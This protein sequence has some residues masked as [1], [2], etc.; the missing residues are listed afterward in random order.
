M[1]QRE[2]GSETGASALSQQ[3]RIFCDLFVANGG[4]GTEAAIEAGYAE[5]SAHV[6]AS[7][8]LC[9]DRVARRIG[10]LVR[11]FAHSNMP[12]VVRLALEIAEDKEALRK[13]R[14][15]ALGLLADWSGM[16]PKAGGITINN[17]NSQTNV[18]GGEVQALMKSLWDA[19]Q[20]RLSGIAGGMSDT[21][22]AIATD[23]AQLAIDAGTTPPGGIVSQGPSP[24]P[25][26]LPPPSSAQPSE[27]R[28]FRRGGASGFDVFNDQGDED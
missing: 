14:L 25:V 5:A 2:A 7:R 4:K 11:R 21:L 8:L 1:S 28:E 27:T 17:S 20:R 15:K 24:A 22:D 23:A 16:A 9:R 19:R 13:D 18:S 26:H 6:A 3:E 10:D 12:T